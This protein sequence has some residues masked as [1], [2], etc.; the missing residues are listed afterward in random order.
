MNV[1]VVG[2]FLGSGK[3]TLLLN[4]LR[5]KFGDGESVASDSFDGAASDEGSVSEGLDEA[6]G[7]GEMLLDTLAPRVVVIENEVGDVDIDARAI[8]SL[9]IG[10]RNMLSGCVCC[11]LVGELLP[12]LADIE[13]RLN[14]AWVVLETTG[15]A[16]SSSIV[17]LIERH[18][19]CA[20]RSLAVVDASRWMK[21][22]QPLEYVLKGQIER[23]NVVAIAKCDLV[24][25]PAVLDAVEADIRAIEP[26]AQVFRLRADE[27]V[28]PALVDAVFEE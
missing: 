8:S 28:P 22:R 12:S 7:E 26:S 13:Q 15:I 21:L 4:L 5:A 23:A 1:L 10:V 3:T 20:C 19:A 24:E 18:S 27:P 2:G 17:G 9:G 14:P 11:T 25:D 16:V 6:L